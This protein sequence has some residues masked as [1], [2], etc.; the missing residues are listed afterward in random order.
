MKLQTKY[1]SGLQF[2]FKHLVLCALTPSYLCPILQNAPRF[3]V[4]IITHTPSLKIDDFDKSTSLT[5]LS[6][7]VCFQEMSEFIMTYENRIGNF[8]LGRYGRLTDKFQQEKRTWQHKTWPYKLHS[9][10]WNTKLCDHDGCSMVRNV[11]I[12]L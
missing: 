11:S 4:P 2:I 8:R 7:L 12:K 1:I 3:F 5:G 6:F 10:R 9:P